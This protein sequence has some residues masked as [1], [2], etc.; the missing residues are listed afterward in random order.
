M[1]GFSLGANVALHAAAASAAI[2][3]VA[4]VAGFTPY[5]TEV[6]G[7]A[8]GG[9]RRLFELHALLPRLGLF[10]ASPAEVP[11]DYDEL[12]A[13]LAPRPTLLH[14]PTQDRDA[15]HADVS[16]CIA[17]AAGAWGAQRAKLNHTSAETGTRMGHAETRLLIEWLSHARARLSVVDRA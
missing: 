7:R 5:R 16:A 14:T 3:G 2:A 11:Y 9:L 10:A 13:A 15:S 17:R 4:S 12:L 6:E 8:T 1:A